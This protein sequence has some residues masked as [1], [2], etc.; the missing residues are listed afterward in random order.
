[1]QRGSQV[2]IVLR[3]DSWIHDSVDREH[4]QTNTKLCS[5]PRTERR[6]CGRPA[7]RSGGAVGTERWRWPCGRW[8]RKLASDPWCSERA[9][10]HRSS[11]A[12]PAAPASGYQEADM[13]GDRLEER[14]THLHIR[15]HYTLFWG[16][17]GD[18]YLQRQMTHTHTHHLCCFKQL[19][20]H[21]NAKPQ[22][23]L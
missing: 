1:M 23:Q 19:T 13:R 15:H 17:W 10:S 21:T 6:T 18:S 12:P 2:Y 5:R 7:P 22:Q 11:A 4:T 3:T 9:A 14:R 8:R 16:V 20:S